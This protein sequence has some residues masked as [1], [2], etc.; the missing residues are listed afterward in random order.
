MKKGVEHCK[1]NLCV[2]YGGFSG[3]YDDLYDS[4]CNNL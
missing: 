2:A 4:V 3:F 1:D